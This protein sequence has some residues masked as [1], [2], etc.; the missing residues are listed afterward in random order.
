MVDRN[1]KGGKVSNENRLKHKQAYEAL[2]LAKAIVKG[3][4][5]PDEPILRKSRDVEQEEPTPKIVPI[6]EVT[7]EPE[8]QKRACRRERFHI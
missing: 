7:P 2:T 1:K 6:Q 4:I 8:I 5:Q 3:D